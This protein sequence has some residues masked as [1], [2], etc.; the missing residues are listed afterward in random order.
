[1]VKD[2]ILA[3]QTSVVRT[4]VALIFM[5]QTFMKHTSAEPISLMQASA[6]LTLPAQTSETQN[7]WG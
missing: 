4:Y 1:M 3:E 7:S 5:E 6:A 2:Q